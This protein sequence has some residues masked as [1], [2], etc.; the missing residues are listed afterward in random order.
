L[1]LVFGVCANELSA[2]GRVVS[3]EYGC[4]AHSDT[5]P[6]EPIGSPAFEPFDYGVLD[7]G[8]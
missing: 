1:G 7:L 2:D 8:T 5:P 3:A 6:P 4:G